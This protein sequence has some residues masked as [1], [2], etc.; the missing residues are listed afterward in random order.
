MHAVLD[1]LVS[2]VTDSELTRSTV[3]IVR[4]RTKE[5]GLR[6]A[7]YRRDLVQRMV[8]H[9][10]N[11]RLGELTRKPDARF[12]GAGVSDGALSPGVSTFSVAV[13]CGIKL[14]SWNTIPTSIRR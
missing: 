9:M 10:F 6:V 2:V 4:K 3:Q 8:E 14:C 1:S 5:S 7:D 13:R 12:L 11:D